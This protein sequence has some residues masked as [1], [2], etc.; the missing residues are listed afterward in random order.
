MVT[1]TYEEHAPADVEQSILDMISNTTLNS[2]SEPSPI[3]W[4]TADDFRDGYIDCRHIFQTMDRVSAYACTAIISP[5]EQQVQFTIYHDDSIRVWLNGEICFERGDCSYSQ[6]DGILQQ[7]Y[8]LV[9]IRLTNYYEDG[10]GFILRVTDEDGEVLEDLMTTSWER[11]PGLN[12]GSGLWERPP[13]LDNRGQETTPTNP[14][15]ETFRTDT[16]DNLTQ[17]PMELSHWAKARSGDWEETAEGIKLYG[18][19]Y[20]GGNSISS[21]SFYNFVDSELFIKWMPYGGNGYNYAGFGVGINIAPGTG[22]TTHHAYGKARTRIYDDIWYYTR[23][24]INADKAYTAVMSTGDYDIDGGM[25]VKSKSG[26]FSSSYR[27]YWGDKLLEYIERTNITVVF[28]DNYAGTSAYMIVAEVKTD[29]TPVQMTIL[30][31]YDFEDAVD[32]PAQFNFTGNWVIDTIGFNSAKSLHNTDSPS[33][34]SL[35]VIDAVAV[36]F[37]F[38]CSGPY[39]SGFT[40]YVDGIQRYTGLCREILD[41]WNELIMPIPGT[42]THTLKWSSRDGASLWIDDI[43][44][45]TLDNGT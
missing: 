14:L 22:G 35:E 38:K 40:F 4:R 18:T 28:D 27:P 44:I 25:V 9:L 42:G 7:G 12:C 11:P 2:S 37:R 33:S 31:S 34:I 1:G 10:W 6:F 21:K 23:I 16:A 26:T 29:A 13:G 5:K 39:S 30:S 43:T 8:N 45:Y 41:Q 19:A 36:S 3:E 20:R 32:V 24:K 15:V 17:I